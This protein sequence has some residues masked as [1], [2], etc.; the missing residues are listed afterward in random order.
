ML[1]EAAPVDY[2][3]LVETIVVLAFILIVGTAA[4]AFGT[5]LIMSAFYSRWGAGVR[6]YVAGPFVSVGVMISWYVFAFIV[7]P[8]WAFLRLR[9][10]RRS[11]ALASS[12]A[13]PEP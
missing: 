7:F 8:I 5:W 1:L 10:R 13:Q 2:G 12:S 6:F 3:Q 4:T 11:S 9:R